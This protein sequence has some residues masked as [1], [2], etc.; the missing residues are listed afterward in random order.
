MS[1]NNYTE[2]QW[3]DIRESYLASPVRETVD[4]L[5]VKYEKS[6]RSIV[7]KLSKEGIYKKQ[8]YRTKLNEIPCTKEELVEMIAKALH[9]PSEILE[10]LEKAPKNALRLILGALDSDALKSLKLD[11][12]D[13]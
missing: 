6:V 9:T 1:K 7:G 4:A 5:A 8:E 3:L 13:D 12:P 2:E 10:G 11:N